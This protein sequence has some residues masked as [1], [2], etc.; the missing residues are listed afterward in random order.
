MSTLYQKIKAKQI[1]TNV[2][3][4]KIGDIE[5]QVKYN[6]KELYEIN[7]IENDNISKLM[8]SVVD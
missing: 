6:D 1:D 5:Y 3:S 7:I 8:Y 2:Y 4:Y